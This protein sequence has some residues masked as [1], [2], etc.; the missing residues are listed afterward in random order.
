MYAVIC[1]TP[2]VLVLDEGVGIYFRFPKNPTDENGFLDYLYASTEMGQNFVGELRL[3]LRELVV[4]VL[5]SAFES[6]G[7]ELLD[8]EAEAPRTILVGPNTRPYRN[9]LPTPA[10]SPASNKRTRSSSGQGHQPSKRAMRD[11]LA[12]QASLD[13][14]VVGATLKLELVPGLSP[15]W[16]RASSPDSGFHEGSVC[17]PKT[18]VRPP[19][20]D[21][22][23]PTIATVTVERLFKQHVA[24]VTDGNTRFIAKLFPPDSN[25]YPDQMLMREL[26]VYRECADL[27][28]GYL[29]YLHGVYRAVRR[30]SRFSSPILLTEFVGTGKTVTEVV[31]LA[32]VLDDDDELDVA[33]GTLKVLQERALDAI[34]VL[35]QR[36]IVHSDLVGDNMLVVDDDHVVLVD[37]GFSRV[38]KDEARRFKNRSEDD[39]RRLK[40]A[41][42]VQYD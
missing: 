27:Q 35:H 25:D 40:R 13:R 3:S 37:F 6:H 10:P 29:P 8:L 34:T 24:L 11:D 42:E 5:F 21:H 9:V 32:G 39:L 7:V 30:G 18:I 33:E 17:S 38:L 16:P 15:R 28:G 12:P 19:L 26:A 4:F 14:L 31:T 41:F 2:D 20:S 36:K 22:E 23:P 1:N